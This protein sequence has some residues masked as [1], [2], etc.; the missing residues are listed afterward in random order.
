MYKPRNYEIAASDG[1]QSRERQSGAHEQSPLSG[2]FKETK[3]GR[4]G[5]EI[6]SPSEPRAA[7]ELAK[8]LIAAETAATYAFI[9]DRECS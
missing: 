5:G 2:S 6:S 3:T 9:S 8:Q 7:L 1:G 4:G